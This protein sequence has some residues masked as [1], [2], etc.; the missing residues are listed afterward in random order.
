MYYVVNFSV[1]VVIYI[2]L[3]GYLIICILIRFG[4]FE[5]FFWFYSVFFLGY[6]VVLGFYFFYIFDK[7]KDNLKIGFIKGGKNVVKKFVFG[8]I[9]L[10]FVCW[11]NIKFWSFGECKIVM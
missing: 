6:V 4:N 5:M 2:L 7:I 10:F 11:Y 8:L 3:L 9:V 1:C